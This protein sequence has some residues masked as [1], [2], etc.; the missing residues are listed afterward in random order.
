[1]VS[2][3]EDWDW[4]YSLEASADASSVP[5]AA[6]ESVKSVHRLRISDRMREAVSQ[7]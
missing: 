2:A 6:V 5:L 4:P 1:M 7:R 3:D